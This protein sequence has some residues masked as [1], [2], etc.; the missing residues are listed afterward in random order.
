MKD[1][2]PRLSYPLTTILLMIAL[3]LT[4][5]CGNEPI[6]RSGKVLLDNAPLSLKGNQKIKVAFIPHDDAQ[7]QSMSNAEK[8]ALVVS[9]NA[10]GTFTIPNV[11]DGSYWAIVSDFDQYPSGD[12][13]AN[14]FR[15]EPQSLKVDLIGDEP[16]VVNLKKEWYSPPNARR[17]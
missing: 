3:P 6:S 7:S 10:D 16:V 5:G 4:I 9:V 14:H 11:V 13:L 15:K 17:K 2:K 1:Q 8:A 12:R